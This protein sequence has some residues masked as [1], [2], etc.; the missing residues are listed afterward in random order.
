MKFDA[1]DA[2]TVIRD[3]LWYINWEPLIL[4]GRET[5]HPMYAFNEHY[6]VNFNAVLPS[7]I[8]LQ[9]PVKRRIR[10]APPG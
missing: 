9:E 6:G 3:Q 2:H 10:R 4:L 8:V 1:M 7:A 5:A